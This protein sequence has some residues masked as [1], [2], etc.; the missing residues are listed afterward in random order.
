MEA[1]LHDAYAQDYDQQV[2]SYGSH[3][4]DAMFGLCYEYIQPG[5]SLLDLG[6][7]SG[8][9]AAPFAKAGLQVRGM[10][11]SAAMLDVCRSK[12]FASELKQHDIR[13][14]PW[15]FPPAAFDHVI[16]C[17]VF[18]FLADLD[19]VFT[20]VIRLLRLGGVF[21][22]TT[23]AAGTASAGGDRFD[24]HAVEGLD[25]FEHHLFYLEGLVERFRFEP[26]KRMRCFVGEDI[27]LVWVTRR[28]PVKNE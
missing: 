2:L 22:F 12:G 27:F 14:T 1:S 28:K 4:A 24:R 18:H 23:K 21:A 13:Q 3:I 15:P 20:E 26:L 11:F 16:C 17:G 19:P 10:D 8:L 9:S 7:G 25:V 5:Q 6:I